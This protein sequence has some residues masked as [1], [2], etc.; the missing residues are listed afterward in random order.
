MRYKICVWS[1]LC[2]TFWIYIWLRSMGQIH[3]RNMG[4]VVTQNQINHLLSSHY[5][6]ICIGTW[7]TIFISDDIDVIWWI[8]LHI[9][10]LWVWLHAIHMNMHRIS[11]IFN[12]F[13]VPQ[14]IS[15]P[16]KWFYIH[17]WR[18]KA[19]YFHQKLQDYMYNLCI[20]SLSISAL[21]IQW[22]VSLFKET[23]SSSLCIIQYYHSRTKKFKFLKALLGT[24]NRFWWRYYD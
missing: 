21:I 22:I 9:I 14:I 11:S 4:I 16:M 20:K 23:I 19:D 10:V 3:I 18:L 15:S 24:S 2:I 12:P 8:W 13:S 7:D 1:V 17:H 5:K 6:S